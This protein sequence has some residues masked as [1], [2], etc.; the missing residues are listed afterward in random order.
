[1]AAG[2]AVSV[3]VHLAVRGAAERNEPS[4]YARELE[5]AII[6]WLVETKNK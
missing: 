5:L 1:M 2:G 4:V 6:Q 3:F